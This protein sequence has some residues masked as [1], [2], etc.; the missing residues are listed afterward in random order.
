MSW[1]VLVGGRRYFAVSGF[2]NDDIVGRISTEL[3]TVDD[4]PSREEPWGEEVV[5]DESNPVHMLHPLETGWPLPD[6]RKS[7]QSWG[8]ST[9]RIFPFGTAPFLPTSRQL[10]TCILCKLRSIRQCFVSVLHSLP[11]PGNSSDFVRFPSFLQGQWELSIDPS[12][13]CLALRFDIQM[14]WR[15]F[16]E[17]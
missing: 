10:V 5:R 6:V 7:A 4:Q 11:K 9:S 3:G 13:C 16:D 2:G 15:R 8:N 12:R 1:S 14:P 17:G